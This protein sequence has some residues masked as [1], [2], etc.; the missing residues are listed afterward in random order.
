[1][2]K[3]RCFGGGKVQEEGSGERGLQGG[4]ADLTGHVLGPHA[5]LGL[6]SPPVA[7]DVCDVVAGIQGI[8]RVLRVDVRHR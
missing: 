1:M 8:V 4:V 2:R 6:H 3:Q 7:E 5:E